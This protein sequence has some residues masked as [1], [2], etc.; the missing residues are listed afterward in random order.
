MLVSNSQY[1]VP[2]MSPCRGSSWNRTWPFPG[3]YRCVYPPGNTRGAITYV[4]PSL[5]NGSWQNDI[6]HQDY[7]VTMQGSISQWHQCIVRRCHFS[8]ISNLI[9][10][11]FVSDL[12]SLGYISPVIFLQ[13]VSHSLQDPSCLKNCQL[14]IESTITHSPTGGLLADR[15]IVSIMLH[16]TRLLVTQVSHLTSITTG[17]TDTQVFSISSV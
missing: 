5:Y 11:W 13:W 10:T 6:H 3:Q 7:Y 4:I 16:C 15:R 1:R 17:F 9:K 12:V 2:E 8:V 14:L